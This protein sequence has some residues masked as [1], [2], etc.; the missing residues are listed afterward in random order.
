MPAGFRYAPDLIDAAAETRLVAAFADLPFK[1][2]EFHGFLGKRRVVS[3]GTR[4]DFNGGGLKPAEPMPPFLLPL[5][6]R[7]AAFAGLAPERLAHAL[8]HRIPAGHDNRL[9]SRPAAL[10]RRDRHLAP[11]ALHFPDAQEAR[12]RLGARRAAARPPLGLSVAR[13]VAR[14]LGAQ[15]PRGG[16]AALF[17]DVPVAAGCR[18]AIVKCSPHERSDMR[19]EPPRDSPGCRFAHPGYARWEHSIPA[20][21]EL[22]YS[23]T[24][25]SLRMPLRDSQM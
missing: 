23:I 14:G 15:H 9:A 17:D 22:R 24:F 1:E 12:H 10:R 5:R 16:G 8:D 18:C 3:F 11:V 6:E 4:Y 7:A 13:A 20:V 2:F 19:D 21:A 25:R